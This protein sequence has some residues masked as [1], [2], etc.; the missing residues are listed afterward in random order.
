MKTT[1]RIEKDVVESGEQIV[2][3][4][5]EL[6]LS[7]T[8]HEKE[9]ERAAATLANI[10]DRL[11]GRARKPK[12]GKFTRRKKGEKLDPSDVTY[13]GMEGVPQRK[14]GEKAAAD[15]TDL[16]GAGPDV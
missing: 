5:D 15:L 9:A 16:I 1:E 12:S 2:R 13:V 7:K 3:L 8:Y 4:I 14:K 11:N 6:E 10:R